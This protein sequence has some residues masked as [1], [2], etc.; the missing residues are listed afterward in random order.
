MKYAIKQP[1]AGYIIIPLLGGIVFGT[2]TIALIETI[3][4]IDLLWYW[5]L[6]ILI[7]FSL[8]TLCLLIYAGRFK[9]YVELVKGSILF[10]VDERRNKKNVRIKVSD[11]EIFEI[12]SLQSNPS[13]GIYYR[14]YARG[15]EMMQIDSYEVPFIDMKNYCRENNIAP[16]Y[17]TV[18]DTEIETVQLGRKRLIIKYTDKKNKPT[19]KINIKDIAY[20]ELITH[21]LSFTQ[22]YYI[23]HTAHGSRYEFSHLWIEYAT[24]KKCSEKNGC[25]ILER[26]AR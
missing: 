26:P 16:V 19:V 20:I 22:N 5:S 18:N 17:I 25:S 3:S 6:A 23:V 4:G 13:E 12:I 1:L 2:I 11:I 15:Q 10:A 21:G 24:I 8:V 9:D 7:L 14:I